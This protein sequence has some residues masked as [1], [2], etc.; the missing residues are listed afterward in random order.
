MKL[1]EVNTPATRKEFLEFPVKLYK[2]EKNWIRPLDKDIEAVFD[3]A[4]NKTFRNGECIRWI[5]QNDQGE[6]I[7]R[8]AAFINQNTSKKNDQPV[9]VFPT[10]CNMPSFAKLKL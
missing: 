1:L 2:N 10:V 9:I 5:L 4:K 8:V 7:G 3:P 6:T